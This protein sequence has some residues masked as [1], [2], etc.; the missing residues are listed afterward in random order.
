VSH[1]FKNRCNYN[2]LNCAHFANINNIISCLS[3]CIFPDKITYPINEQQLHIGPP[4]FSNLGYAYAKRM[5]EIHSRTYNEQYNR[6]YKCII[7]VNIYGPYDNFNLEDG[8]VIPSLIHRCYLAK[9]NKESFIVKGSGKPLRQFIYSED[10]A[11]L[12]MIV[13]EKYE[14]REP[15]ILAVDEENT[16]REAA[17]YIAECFEMNDLIFDTSFEDGQYKKTA[18][19]SKIKN[20]CDYKFKSLKEGIKESVKWFKENYEIARK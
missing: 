15:I 4:H 16:I 7:P 19:N 20:L 6:N 10:L 9:K 8:H 18:D 13:L 17:E 2:V 11:N 12:I 1:L 14:E 3:T 5:L